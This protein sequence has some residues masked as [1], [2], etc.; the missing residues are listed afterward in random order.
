MSRDGSNLSAEGAHRRDRLGFGVRSVTRIGGNILFL[1]MMESIESNPSLAG[2]KSERAKQ[3]SKRVNRD[4]FDLLAE[5]AH[6]GCRSGF[7]VSQIAI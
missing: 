6:R 1:T 5:G 2:C 7:R 3:A 4:G